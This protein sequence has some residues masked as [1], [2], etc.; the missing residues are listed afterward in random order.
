MTAFGVAVVRQTTPASGTFDISVTH[1]S[2]DDAFSAVNLAGLTV[3][4]VAEDPFPFVG[5]GYY[6]VEG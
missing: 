6:P 3:P 4:A 1:A 2:D 5:G